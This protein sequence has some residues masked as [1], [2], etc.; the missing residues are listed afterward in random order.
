MSGQYKRWWSGR[1]SPG[2]LKAPCPVVWGCD[3]H[4]R[5]TYTACVEIHRKGGRGEDGKRCADTRNARMGGTR[6]EA[7]A[8]TLSA[9]TQGPTSDGGGLTWMLFSCRFR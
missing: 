6:R 3:R 9:L 2:Y 7:E 1:A 4:P 8:C 5:K